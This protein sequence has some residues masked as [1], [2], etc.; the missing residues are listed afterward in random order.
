MNAILVDNDPQEMEHLKKFLQSHKWDVESIDY[1]GEAQMEEQI[2]SAV[3][4]SE[5]GLVVVLDV[6]YTADEEDR[7]VS[8]EKPEE[9]IAFS[10]FRLL[11]QIKSI[12]PTTV[13]FLFS[14]NPSNVLGIAATE[15]GADG[16]LSKNR[17]EDAAN[18][19]LS[20]VRRKLLCSLEFHDAIEQSLAGGDSWKTFFKRAFE[21]FFLR[22]SPVHRFGNLCANLKP[23]VIKI[24]PDNADLM[25]NLW[26]RLEDTHALLSLVDKGVRD[27]VKHTGNVF[28]IGYYILQ[29]V[30]RYR[31]INST[32][33]SQSKVFA[34]QQVMPYD[35]QLLLGWVIASL[36]H[37]WA[38][39]DQKTAN[40]NTLVKRVYP[41]A[42]ISFKS[43][44]KSSLKAALDPLRL[45]IASVESEN[46]KT[47]KVL[48]WMIKN[49]GKNIELNYSKEK[50]KQVVDH[51]ILGAA[52]LLNMT[53]EGVTPEYKPLFLQAV[54]A[55]A[56]HNL[57][58]WQRC[59][60]EQGMPKDINIPFEQYPLCGL[61]ALSDNVQTWEREHENPLAAV[62]DPTLRDLTMAYVRTGEVV[63]FGIECPQ[64]SDAQCTLNVATR[65]SVTYGAQYKAACAELRNAIMTWKEQ[66]HL[67]NVIDVFSLKDMFRVKLKYEIPFEPDIDVDSES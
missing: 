16:T 56:L 27:H 32:A 42:K 45:F 51:G 53:S 6:A 37:D 18:L 31:N 17:L 4:A 65:Y 57:A 44:T 29:N 28:W 10:G 38:Y 40:V 34:N 5:P 47:V 64:D 14:K 58:D 3:S 33:G 19:M 61:L 54:L 8:A 12:R 21:G 63:D 23:F 2:I 43:F 41:K 22:T 7:I 30:Y 35:Q 13:V 67:I 24:M 48:D 66:K 9:L 60:S 59:W 46:S 50:P 20:I 49:W 15:C 55:I 26:R 62:I 25:D 11:Q 52:S 36:F 39:A 1:N